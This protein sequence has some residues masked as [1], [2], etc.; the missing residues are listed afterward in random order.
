M[1]EP[2][3]ID[4]TATGS[5]IVQA[6]A[7]ASAVLNVY[8]NVTSRTVKPEDLAAAEKLLSGLP[9]ELVPSVAA[10]P[11]AS[12]VAYR[13][14]PL[15]VGREDQLR[16]LALALRSSRAAAVTG[17]PGIGKTQVASEFVHRY[18]QYFGGGVFWLSFADPRA[19]AT[20]IATCGSAE[21][22]AVR[23][24]FSSL[25]LN[26]QVGL[27]LAAWASPLPRLLVFDNCEDAALLDQWG[28]QTGGCRVLLTSRRAEWPAALDVRVVS[29]RL[30]S[31]EDSVALL[32]QYL[33]DAQADT[34]VLAEI[35][36]TLDY[37]PLVLHVV[38]SQ[39]ERYR[40]GVAP[41]TLLEQLRRQTGLLKTRWLR[42]SAPSPTRH[43]Q[44]ITITFALIYDQFDRTNPTDV[45]AL[46]LFARAAHLPPGEPIP[47]QLLLATAKVPEDDFDAQIEAQDALARLLEHGMLERVGANTFRMHRL[48]AA[49]VQE[50]AADEGA[51]IAVEEAVLNLAIKNTREPS[52]SATLALHP[53]VSYVSDAA[54]ARGDGQAAGLH[55]AMGDYLMRL[56][57]F[58]GARE[59]YQKAL[60]IYEERLGDQHPDTV[61]AIHRLGVAYKERGEYVEARRHFEWALRASQAM[62]GD[63]HPQTVTHLTSLAFM[64]K[65]QGE[66]DKAKAL[67]ARALELTRAHQGMR[68]LETALSLNNLGL[69]YKDLHHVG[70]AQQCF[71]EAL[72]ICRSV[73]GERHPTAVVSLNN[74]AFVLKDQ[75]KLAEA[76]KHFERALEISRAIHGEEH[77]ET[78]ASLN[79]LAFLFFDLAAL[80]ER[81]PRRGL[82]AATLFDQARVYLEGALAIQERTLPE[83][84]PRIAESLNSL[85]ELLAR[86]GD[87]HGAQGYLSRALAIRQ[88]TLGNSHP[89]TA[90]TLTVLGLMF[91]SQ[92]NQWRERG[93]RPAE[94]YLPRYPEQRNQPAILAGEGSCLTTAKQYLEQ[95]VTAFDSVGSWSLSDDATR[96]RSMLEE[97][98][99]RLGEDTDPNRF[100]PPPM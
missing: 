98:K 86:Q 83:R 64:L 61:D 43:E 53:F 32:C 11:A 69:I 72:E 56:G 74:L 77:P 22:L 33:K 28:P 68:S 18:G 31:P 59:S 36:E 34:R 41:A 44:Q 75:G 60:A 73:E 35:A 24:D 39:L 2:P 63:E 37:L 65:D 23:P 19:V 17:M 1:A 30:F 85:G 89:D 90:K 55:A 29:L 97:V 99:Q 38:G 50:R 58:L 82:N 15:F 26:D 78:I 13:P 21:H 93:H 12:R 5:Y 14:N 57:D 66:Y 81:K 70:K 8:H 62:W 47:Q 46:S 100:A 48:W 4:Q 25:T 51:Q 92:A 49:F 80:A 88:Q 71:E 96:A 52:P 79:N 45:L 3:A 42:S 54:V 95:A 67:F 9:T 27:V 94:P 10:L 16:A 76:R 40:H 87:F 7:G 91:V 84:H 20:E 6:A